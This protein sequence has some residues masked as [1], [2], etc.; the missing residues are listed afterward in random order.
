MTEELPGPLIE[1]RQLTYV[2]AIVN[3]CVY[4]KLTS[5]FPKFSFLPCTA[6]KR[7][8]TVFNTSLLLEKPLKNLELT[9]NYYEN[10]SIKTSYLYLRVYDPLTVW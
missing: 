4:H 5:L 8:I 1:A 10:G 2:S 3:L 9:H 7:L 6:T